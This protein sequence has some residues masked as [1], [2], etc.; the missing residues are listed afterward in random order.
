MQKNLE[1]LVSELEPVEHFLLKQYSELEPV[2]HFLL[3][4]YLAQKDNCQQRHNSFYK[5]IQGMDLFWHY[6]L[7]SYF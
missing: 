1:Y 5:Q 4:Q 6:I 3:E 7:F 2:E